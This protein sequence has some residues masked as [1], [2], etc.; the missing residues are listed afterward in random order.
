MQKYLKIISDNN[1]YKFQKRFYNQS[2]LLLK[3]FGKAINQNINK[4]NIIVITDTHNTLN[5]GELSNIVNL[6]PNYDLCVLL[7]DHNNNDIDIILKYIDKNK[8]YCLLGNH[9][10]NYIKNYSLNNLNGKIIEVNGVKIMGIQGSF[11]YKPADFPSF[12]QE[13]SIEFLKDKEAVDIL[14]SHDSPFDDN[15]I[16]N[17]AHQGLFGITYYLYKNKVKYNI[18]GHLHNPYEKKLLNGTKE[19][20]LYGVNYLNLD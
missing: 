2:K 15:M 14:F 16:N 6:H 8:L 17:P 1:V 9:D 12:T 11:K 4:L 5:E 10:N 18:H 19:I 13:E 20:S 7:G 3:L